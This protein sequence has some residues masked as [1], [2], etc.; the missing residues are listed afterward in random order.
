ME[1]SNTFSRPTWA[2][3]WLPYSNSSR[4]TERAVPSCF[5][6]WDTMRMTSCGKIWAAG[7]PL[8]KQDDYST[9][10]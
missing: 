9:F 2:A 1:K 8:Y 10:V 3:R 6:R 5:M 4:I 7:R